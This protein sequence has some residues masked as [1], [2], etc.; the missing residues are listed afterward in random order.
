MTDEQVSTSDHSRDRLDYRYLYTVLSRRAGGISLGI[1]LNPDGI[2]NWHCAYCQVSRP[3]ESVKPEPVEFQR[4]CEELTDLLAAVRDGTLLEHPLHRG[5]PAELRQVKDISFSGDGEPTTASCFPA[6]VD[7]LLAERERLGLMDLNM[8]LLSNC[9]MADRPSVAQALRR[10][11]QAGGQ[12]HGK[13]DG[14]GAAAYE[15]VDRTAV[16]FQQTLDNLLAA[17]RL[18]PLV[19]QSLFCEVGGE[20]ADG[21]E[22]DLFTS[23]LSDLLDGGAQLQAL[24]LHTVA[25]PP[26]FADVKAVPVEFLQALAVR[27]LSREPRLKGR[28]EVFAGDDRWLTDRTLPVL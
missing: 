1:N 20:T 23:H 4:F 22:V 7:H 6:A 24:H 28:I 9:S 11:G 17:G 26:P 15:R 3:R 2:C 25:R 18:A 21:S 13:L 12:V 14:G 5:L 19:I 10:F 16:P 27:V 8:I